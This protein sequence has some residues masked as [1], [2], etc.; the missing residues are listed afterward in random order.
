MCKRTKNSKNYNHLKSVLGKN[1]MWKCL[2]KR[3]SCS[4]TSKKD[5][6]WS[7]ISS[8]LS[9]DMNS[10]FIG[11]VSDAGKDWGQKEKRVSED[12]I[13]G[14]HHQWNGHKVGQTL[15]DDEGQRGLACCSPWCTESSTWLGHWATPPLA[16]NTQSKSRKRRMVPC[17]SV[18]RQP[19]PM[20]KTDLGGSTSRLLSILYCL[21]I[22]QIAW[23]YPK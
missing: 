15:R 16:K 11:K 6:C 5:W 8:I 23:I 1:R 22:C 9:S 20:R 4:V 19:R 10:W 12:E 18:Y 13:A 17:E 3:K 7:W 2:Q 21:F 14:W